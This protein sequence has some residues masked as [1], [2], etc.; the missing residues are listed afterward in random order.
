M[1]NNKAMGVTTKLY[2]DTRKKKKDS[3]Y[4]VKLR[5]I[6]RRKS[7][8]YATGYD[9]T[10]AEFKK[11]MGEKPRGDFKEIDIELS[12]IEKK[13]IDIIND[14]KT[15]SFDTF[16]F[17]FTGKT[18]DESNVYHAFE[19][20][21][22]ELR[23]ERR[24]GTADSYQCALSSIKSYHKQKELSYEDITPKFLSKYESW[25]RSKGNSPTTVGIYLRPLRCIFNLGIRRGIVKQELYPFGKDGDKYRIPE[26]RSVNKALSI[27]DI[28]KIF[29]YKPEKG[30]SEELYRDIWIFSY[31]SNG[32]NI[33]DICQLKYCDLS[34]DIITFI[35]AK[36]SRTN[37][38]IK[39]IVAIQNNEVKDIISRWG[40]SPPLLDQYVFPFLRDRLSPE[41]QHAKIRQ[42]VKLTNKYI[43]RIA[44]KVGIPVHIT[45]YSSRHSFSSILKRSGTPIAYISEALGH[46]SVKTTESYLGS[47]ETEEK[48]KIAANLT[49]WENF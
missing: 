35:R 44:S 3:K 24:I 47:F 16:R 46:S 42:T 5:V 4:P 31:L 34:D 14:L 43:S 6:Y 36:T 2:L 40:N 20:Y 12:A 37:R 28:K 23:F 22:K 17:R 15:F 30:S 13:A 27:K 25:M 32:V 39:P 41:E 49:N 45:T 18:S 8:Y 21:I 9:L 7:R 11:V 38:R 26:P 48:K 10:K 29:M 33:K 1:S 19:E